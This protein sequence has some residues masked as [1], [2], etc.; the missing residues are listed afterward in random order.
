MANTE[1]LA[2]TRTWGERLGSEAGL[3]RRR[4]RHDAAW[5][6]A[7]G[8]LA[9]RLTSLTARNHERFER[10]EMA[11]GGAPGPATAPVAGPPPAEDIVP[12]PVVLARL[13]DAIGPVAS[14][15]RM[16][17][18]NPPQLVAGGVAADAVTIGTDIFF[19]PGLYQPGSAQG[20]GLLVHESLHAAAAVSPGAQRR[21]SSPLAAADEEQQALRL[22]RE[23]RG[24]AGLPGPGGPPAGHRPPV[25]ADR[26]AW[27][28]PAAPHPAPAA[29]PHPAAAH[30][31]AGPMAAHPAGRPMA[32]AQDRDL[33]APPAAPPDLA[34]LRR[35]VHQDLLTRIRTEFER[36]A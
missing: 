12:S 13:A 1:Q 14:A 26:Q 9:A 33:S 6:T 34:E 8:P 30:P 19:R 16:H 36:G 22:E 35:Q 32:A 4:I 2:P 24:A 25:P 29:A 15:V 18:A 28:A 7:L 31:A 17:V 5:L 10:I 27:P 21:R 20:F 23:M 11:P 3:I